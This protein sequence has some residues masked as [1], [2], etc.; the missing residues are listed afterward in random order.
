[1]P[2]H[3]FFGDIFKKAAISASFF[4]KGSRAF[5]ALHCEYASN[6]VSS[7]LF[8]TQYLLLLI[9]MLLAPTNV[10]LDT[11]PRFLLAKEVVVVVVV[12]VVVVV[13]VEVVVVVVVVVIEILVVV[14]A[15]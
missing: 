8:T 5:A 7:P 4:G 9:L 3:V 13:V 11:I 10:H 6:R 14:E 12:E 15:T 1:M 2:I